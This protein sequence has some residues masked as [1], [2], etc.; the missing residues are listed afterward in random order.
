MRITT[1]IEAYI[2][3]TII[4]KYL[5]FDEAHNLEHIEK[6]IENSLTIAR[7]Y[8]V[9]INKVYVVAAY[10]DIGL[11]YGRKGHEK[12]SAKILLSDEKLKE[13]F[14]DEELVLM[15]EAIEDHRASNAYEPR[16]IYGKIISE[17]DRDIEYMTVLRRTIQYGLK[18]YPDYTME[19]H[20]ARTYEHVQNK[21]GENGYIKLWLH[22][23]LN[24]SRL[25]ELRSKVRS[26]ETLRLD[27][28]KLFL[29]LK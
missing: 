16:S 18:Q 1:E 14:S 13:W 20:F 9:D 24:K 12:A 8:D 15:S 29:E 22:T 28:D 5:S 17:A 3:T 23:D 27:F 6:V 7:T 11:S 25:H 26:P 2:E 19:Q 10:H 21:Y 4:P